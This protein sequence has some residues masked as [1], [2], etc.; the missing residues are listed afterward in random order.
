MDWARVANS[1][2]D[3]AREIG[4]DFFLEHEVTNI[5]RRASLTVLHTT[6]GEVQAKYVITCAGV[7]SDKVAQMTGGGRDPQIIPFRGDYMVLKRPRSRT[8]SEATSIP[9]PDPAFPFLGVHFTPRMDGSVWLGPN[10]VLAF[11]REGY[12]FWDVNLNELWESVTYPGFKKLASEYWRLGAEEMRRDLIRS[13]YVKALQR[14]I[15]ELRTEDCEPGPSGIRAQAMAPDGTLVDDFVFEGGEGIMHV[16]NAPSPGATSSLAI[17][18]YIVDDAEKRF[19]LG[20]PVE[21][22]PKPRASSGGDGKSELHSERERRFRSAVRRRRLADAAA[23]APARSHRRHPQHAA[24]RTRPQACPAV[25]SNLPRDTFS[26]RSIWI[27]PTTFRIRRRPMRR[28][29]LRP[30]ASPK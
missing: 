21:P 2:A 22:A 8:S 23:L 12:K 24:R 26:E 19:D 16:R 1:Y 28:A 4:A 18:K 27:M 5:T 7:Y 11:A 15:P 17:G 20:K 10:A 25:K 14:Y 29:S 13:D 6:N 3:D 9:V 30:N